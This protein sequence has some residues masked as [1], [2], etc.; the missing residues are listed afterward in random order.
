VG[1][2]TWHSGGL[3]GCWR[4]GQVA[5]H[6][7][8]FLVDKILYELGEL[9]GQGS[10]AS[11]Y[12]C[13]E[14]SSQSQFAVKVIRRTVAPFANLP[15]ILQEIDLLKRLTH[16]SVV[17][18]HDVY[19]AKDSVSMVLDRC[20]GDLV[21][22]VQ[23]HWASSGQVQV[24]VFRRLC[25]MMVESVAWLH[26][27]NVVHRDVKCENFLLDRLDLS[28][29][30]CRV[31]LADL[32]S[33]V[34]VRPGQRL[35][36]KCGTRAYWAP[37]FFDLDYGTAVDMWAIGV[38]AFT[39]MTGRFPFNDDGECQKRTADFS[40][41]PSQADAQAKAFVLDL[42]VRDEASRLTAE[43]ALKHLFF[44]S[45]S[46]LAQA[47]AERAETVSRRGRKAEQGRRL[48]SASMKWLLG[49]LRPEFGV[50]QLDNMR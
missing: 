48:A 49:H 44:V 3:G 27:N 41:S 14:K 38:V 21:E 37:E 36:E 25:Q 7:Q 19:Y 18:L 5:E 30:A 6:V 20:A 22:G 2:T 34:G 33:A 11:V 10:C 23:R 4:T 39:I 45:R 8:Q 17:R 1:C 42:L 29:P 24:P 46:D 47:A 9:L 26:Q 13:C 12:T 28:D 31:I 40:A 32:G 16:P 15:Q 50:A 43:Q 35:S